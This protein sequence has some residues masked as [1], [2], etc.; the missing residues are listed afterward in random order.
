[1][2]VSR[3]FAQCTEALLVRG[4]VG[5]LSVLPVAVASK[6]GGGLAGLIGPFLSVSRKV[7]DA[8]L[9]LVMPELSAT[10]RT[11]IIKKVWVNLGQTAAEL[12]KLR[13][14]KEV[15]IDSGKPGYTLEGW[16]ENVLPYITQGK[17]AIFFTG[18][19]ANWEVMPLMAH[20]RGLDFGFIY[21][22][23]SNRSVDNILQRLRRSCYGDDVKM[24]PKGAAGG[25][26]AYA[27]LSKGGVLGL[28]VDQKL[29]TG[30]SIPFFGK[31]AMTMDAMASFALRFG[32]PVFPVHVR[33]L[34]PARLQV[35]SDP[36]LVLPQT[37]NRQEDILTLTK[38]MN[39]V[40]EGW[41]RQQPQDWL[42]LHKRWPAQPR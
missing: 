34:G 17:P 8:N 13:S 11:S 4:L 19:L 10:D 37:G 16:E 15:K 6:L 1:M 35:I 12:T 26:A 25:K 33:R 30:L 9:R 5:L 2:S 24:F 36:P 40:V 22:A 42:W 21:R 7:G 29:D 41:I 18:H 14:L 31:Q 20:A 39:C 23:A 28:L 32:C 27:H 3:N 38:D